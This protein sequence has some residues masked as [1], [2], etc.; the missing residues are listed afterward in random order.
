[1]KDELIQQFELH[2]VDSGSVLFTWLPVEWKLKVYSVV[3]LKEI[4][5]R[6]WVVRK[7]YETTMPRHSLNRGWNNNI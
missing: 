5:N 3:T 2:D 1:M 4:P 6:K 7:C